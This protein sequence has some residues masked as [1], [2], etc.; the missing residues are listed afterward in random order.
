MG[1][2]KQARL[3]WQWWNHLATGIRSRG[4]RVLNVNLDETSVPILQTATRGNILA[5]PRPESG[6]LHP[7]L[8]TARACARANFT[9]V[10]MICDDS[11]V[12]PLLPQ[13][14]LVGEHVAR[15]RD[16]IELRANL[17]RNTFV[18]RLE[19]GWTNT[20][21]H[22][23]ILHLLHDAPAPLTAEYEVILSMDACK[24][25]LSHESI[26]ELA[27][28]PIHMVIIPAKT[29]WLLQP[30]DTHVALSPLSLI[31]I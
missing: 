11:T 9:H 13:V 3:V 28:T 19:K 20:A 18:H 12:Q 25:H 10:A 15:A 29:T 16:M 30:L 21:M 23:H 26:T 27:T 5:V 24:V 7:V 8:H 6:K 1:S 4:K 22:R 2:P 17:P 14:I 31:H